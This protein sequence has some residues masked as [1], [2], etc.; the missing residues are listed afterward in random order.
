MGQSLESVTRWHQ[1]RSDVTYGGQSG[2]AHVSSDYRCIVKGCL[3]V[4]HQHFTL[5]YSVVISRLA[6]IQLWPN[7]K[8]AVS[9]NN[10]RLNLF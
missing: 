10:V 2:S 8:K 1:L 9:N 7:T 6:Y 4:S 5:R 3:G